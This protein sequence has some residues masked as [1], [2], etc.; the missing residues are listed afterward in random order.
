MIISHPLLREGAHAFTDSIK[1]AL[2]YIMNVSFAALLWVLTLYLFV[3]LADQG[4]HGHWAVSITGQGC[5]VI[6]PHR[7]PVTHPVFPQ[8]S[9]QKAFVFEGM[10]ASYAMKGRVITFILAAFTKG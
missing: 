5:L 2:G 10:N 1:Q 7:S 9:I 4:L 8:K 6:G 3:W